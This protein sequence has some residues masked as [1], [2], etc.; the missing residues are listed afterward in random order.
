[1]ISPDEI[2]L[3]IHEQSIYF[4]SSVPVST[5]RR[6]TAAVAPAAHICWQLQHIK[7][8]SGIRIIKNI[9]LKRA[10]AILL[11]RYWNIELS[12]QRWPRNELTWFTQC[13]P[14][15]RGIA[16]RVEYQMSHLSV[17]SGWIVLYYSTSQIMTQVD[18][19]L[20]SWRPRCAS[21]LKASLASFCPWIDNHGA[22]FKPQLSQAV[23]VSHD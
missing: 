11:L 21:Q 20:S 9:S 6:Q 3:I 22:W 7:Q 23:T 15:K 5:K 12:S 18:V 2:S 1:M 10:Y 14:W 4:P 16:S 13:F 17:E 8:H 19:W